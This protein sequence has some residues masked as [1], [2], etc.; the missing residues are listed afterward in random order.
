MY[1]PT[2]R[3]KEKLAANRSFIYN[4]SKMI[5]EINIHEA[6]LWSAS[7]LRPSSIRS[8]LSRTKTSKGDYQR[9]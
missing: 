2:R 9:S 3:K 4:F 7:F 1:K 8:F 6:G 5:F